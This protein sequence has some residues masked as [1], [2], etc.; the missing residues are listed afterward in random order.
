M[1]ETAELRDLNDFAMRPGPALCSMAAS[2]RPPIPSGSDG[3]AGGQ[4]SSSPTGDI[5]IHDPAPARVGTRAMETAPVGVGDL[6]LHRRELTGYCQRIVGASEA[7][8]AVQ[9]T[10]LR[11]WRA[12]ADF[13]GRSSVRAWLYRIAANTCLDLL[14]GRERRGRLGQRLQASAEVSTVGASSADPA[15]FAATQDGVRH[16]LTAV[17]GQL[18]ARQRAALI[19]CEVLRWRSDEAAHVLGT[20]AAAVASSLQ[21]ARVTLARQSDPPDPGNVDADQLARYQDAFRRYDIAALVGMIRVETS[22]APDDHQPA[23]RR[24]PIPT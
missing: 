2:A 13:A 6:E 8:D 15:E 7:D 11:A 21:R 22:Q 17:L 24:N 19:L 14:R 23:T 1:P 9:E 20:T 3:I 12:S 5:G 10:M 18:P 16:A 4:R